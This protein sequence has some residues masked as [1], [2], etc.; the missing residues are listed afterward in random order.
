METHKRSIVKSI[1]FRILAT[2]IT[3]VLVWI[4]TKD[5]TLATSVGLLEVVLKLIAYYFHERAWGC[6]SWGMTKE[7]QKA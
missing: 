2:V 3:M 5:L 1:T 4:F 7:D 6:I